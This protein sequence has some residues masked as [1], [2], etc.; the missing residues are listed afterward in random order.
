MSITAAGRRE[1]TLFSGVEVYPAREKPTVGARQKNVT[2]DNGR[3]KVLHVLISLEMGGL[4][5]GVAN[6]ARGLPPGEFDIHAC[7][8]ERSGPFAQN[9]PRP[10]NVQVLHKPQGFSWKAVRDLHRLIRRLRPHVLHSHNLGPLMYASLASGM[11]GWCPLLHGEHHL[12]PP[13]DFDRKRIFQR[14]VFYR[15]CRKVHTVSEG[16]R[17]E[18][19]SRGLPAEKLVTLRNGVD[20]E[21]F[22]PGDRCA[23][24]EKIGG[25][26]PDALVLGMV[27][28]FMPWKGHALLIE[29]FEKIA[30]RRPNAHLLL[31][32]SGGTDE[33]KIRAQAR[34]S[35]LAP[36][37]HFAGFQR[38]VT[39]YYQAMDALIF[40]STIEGLANAV[41]EAMACGVPAL[42]H[43]ACGMAEIITH[44]QD[45]WLAEINTPE[46][47][48][49]Q[50]E[51]LP[52]DPEG[53]SAL[54]RAGRE[55]VLRQF[56]LPGMVENYRRLYREAAGTARP[57]ES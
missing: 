23:A 35:R 24:R 57:G 4:E 41:L 29:A 43:P 36:R 5:N 20:S 2:M 30:S 16:L 45:G 13:A 31:V 50:L 22:K 39:L 53:F 8:L 15:A 42:A 10:E 46:G 47:L 19:I 54:G 9:L 27:G 52:A 6:V 32:G 44:R 14:S 26:P 49:R 17:Q 34:A 12:P 11:G 37:I 7:C 28:R 3:I 33:E 48:L 21:R 56:S 38:D 1:K 18:L 55:K 51:A 40:P 25:L